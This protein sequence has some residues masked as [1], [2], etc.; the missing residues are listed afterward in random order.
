MMIMPIL[1]K[2]YGWLIRMGVS[3]VLSGLLGIGLLAFINQ[4]LL[5][6][7]MGL[8]SALILFIGLVTVYFVVSTYAQMQLTSL[9]HQ[10]VLELRVRLLKQILD[11][12]WNVLK[13]ITK[14][15]LMTSLSNDV[16]YISYA[17][18][19]MP[20][21]FQGGLF[22]LMA[23]AYMFYLS[24]AI[25]GVTMIWIVATLVG[26][27]WSVIRVYK[28][29]I[30]VRA[31]DDHI[32]KDYESV[33]EGFKELAL[34]R[35]R[36]HALYKRFTQTTT[37]YRQHIVAADNAHAFAGNF[38]NV[39]MLAAVGLMFYL[40]AYQ[41]WASM[42]VAITLAITLLFIR[43]PLISAVGAFPTLLQAR[44]SLNTIEALQL[45]AYEDHFQLPAPIATDWQKLT[46][47]DVRYTYENKTDFELKPINLTI[48]RGE[49]IFLVGANGSGKST[50]SMLLAGLYQP[51]GGHLFV[52]DIEINAQNDTAYRQLF[53]SVFTDFYLFSELI[54]GQGKPAD[55]QLIEHWVT[56]LQMQGKVPVKDGCLSNVAMSQGQRKRLGLLL[57]VVENKQILIL[58]EWAADQD[59]SFRKVFYE[60]LLPLLKLQGYTIFAISHDDKYFHHADRILEMKQGALVQNDAG[61]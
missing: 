4:Y 25:F 20:E 44:V 33:Y 2:H 21:L 18:V 6:V 35:H 34:N 55:Q 14:P 11:S 7:N 9:G 40:S 48:T 58:D 39:M 42:E 3:S 27:T 12:D 52:D 57:S 53:A 45:D 15:R 10:L 30:E 23:C 5:Q 32:H 36:A 56:L 19:R 37:T 22:V 43:T 54:D 8:T 51:T 46:L 24:P 60:E 13:K 1:R 38:T 28:H 50:L 17:F 16:Q 47:R 59:P 61:N 41:Q 31:I 29:L 49:T 26:G